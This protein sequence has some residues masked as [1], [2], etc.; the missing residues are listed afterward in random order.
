MP[1]FATSDRTLQQARELM[2]LVGCTAREIDIR[3]SCLAML[4]DLDHPYSRGEPVYDVTFENVQAGERTNHLFRLANHNHAIVIGTGDLQ[5]TGAGLVYLR[6]GRPHVALQRQRQR[7]Q[8]ADQPPGALGG[9]DRAGGRGRPGCAA[10]GAGH[11]HQPGTGAQR[12]T[13]AGQDKA[14]EQKT[15]QIIGPYELQDFNLYYTL[16]FGF[17]PSKVA[18]LALHAWGDAARGTWPNGP[19][20]ARNVYQLPEIKRVLGIFVDRFFRT[21]QFKRSCIPNAPKVGSGGS[22]SRAATGARRAMASRSCGCGIWRGSRIESAEI[23]CDRGQ[24]GSDRNRH[25]VFRA[26]ILHLPTYL[27]TEA[28]H[29]ADYRHHQTVQARR[30]A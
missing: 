14:P 21:S 12:S 29:E 30:S 17:T 19:H 18:F 6:R 20:V 7:A 11:R 8:D 23:G 22:L 26:R 3:P 5:R 4:A 15:E 1:G 10:G 28:S 13:A 16:R 24:C 25:V 9:R 2:K 27:E